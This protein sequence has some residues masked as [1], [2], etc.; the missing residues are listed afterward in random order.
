M[1]DT[2]T[3]IED[4]IRKSSL[5]D[6]WIANYDLEQRH[7]ATAYADSKDLFPEEHTFTFENGGWAD[8]FTE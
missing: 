2:G 7:K 5:S 8:V 3:L 4:S 6:R 1:K